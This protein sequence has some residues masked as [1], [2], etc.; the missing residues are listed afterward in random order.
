MDKPKT[1]KCITLEESNGLRCAV[2][3]MQGWRI[4]MEDRH[5]YKANL[6][7]NL[8]DW[9]YFAVF[10]GHVGVTAAE[11]CSEHLLDTILSIG[12]DFKRDPRNAIVNGFL[13]VDKNLRSLP[14]M[15]TRENKSGM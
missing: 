11:Y 12:T 3:T 1:E 13:E 6:G 2:G 9:S 14:E 5:T 8:E 15:S 10:D 7:P 4:T